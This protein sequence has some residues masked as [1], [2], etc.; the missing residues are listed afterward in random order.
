MVKLTF[1]YNRTTEKAR[2]GHL[3]A[4]IWRMFCNT[5]HIGNSHSAD[6]VDIFQVWKMPFCA[7]T[8]Q[9]PEFGQKYRSRQVFHSSFHTFKH[10]SSTHYASVTELDEGTQKNKTQPFPSNEFRSF[11]RVCNL[12]KEADT[13][14][15][16]IL[17]V[18]T[19]IGNGTQRI[20]VKETQS[21]VV[22]ELL[23]RML[24]KRGSR[25]TMNHPRLSSFSMETGNCKAYLLLV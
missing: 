25:S 21:Q 9:W 14:T 22:K 15:D 11:I 13:W 16:N 12:M 8:W 1:G 10:L 17:S 4:S 20:Q 5:W 18:G 3:M 19:V 23:G 24:R 2:N 7:I 6:Y